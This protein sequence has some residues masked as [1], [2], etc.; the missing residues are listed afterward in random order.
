MWRQLIDA[1]L[2]SNEFKTQLKEAMRLAIINKQKFYDEQLIKINKQIVKEQVN[3]LK[4]WCDFGVRKAWLYYIKDGNL[5]EI[6]TNW[7]QEELHRLAVFSLESSQARGRITQARGRVTQARG[8]VTQAGVPNLTAEDKERRAQ[9]LDYLQSMGITSDEDEQAKRVALHYL[10]TET[11]CVDFPQHWVRD[12]S[13]NADPELRQIVADSDA[14]KEI[15]NANATFFNA[16][17]E[18]QRIEQIRREIRSAP[19]V[20]KRVDLLIDALQKMDEEIVGET[21]NHFK[22]QIAKVVESF[23]ANP[24]QFEKAYLNISLT[25]PPGVGKSTVANFVGQVFALLGVLVSNKMSVHTRATM[26][27]QVVGETVNK[28]NSILR[29]N[30]EGLI[31]IDEAY[32]LTQTQAGSG[33]KEYDLYGVEAINTLVGFLDKEQYKGKICIIAAGYEEEMKTYFFDVNSGMQRRFKYF[34]ELPPFSPSELVCVAAMKLQSFDFNCRTRRTIWESMDT[35]A[36]PQAQTILSTLL[37]DTSSLGD[38]G[39][40]DYFQNEGGDMENLAADISSSY[41]TL[42]AQQL[43]ASR[44]LRVIWNFIKTRDGFVLVA[45][46]KPNKRPARFEEITKDQVSFSFS[47]PTNEL[48]IKLPDIELKLPF[49]KAACAFPQ[50][51]KRP[52]NPGWC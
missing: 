31:F 49:Q 16:L 8:R 12:G 3:L 6:S 37:Q 14:V 1:H 34:W 27:G 41:Y 47:S 40:R 33:K 22:D 26:I 52:V 20:E 9:L 19:P 38:F 39:F 13:A 23:A 50:D 5:R 44:M 18:A 32:A 45:R 29:A 7:M 30:I 28:V 25:G 36:D 15:E 10:S 21:R 48:I 43:T 2:K 51:R 17:T 46:G 11:K 24:E 35:M 4:S 42:G